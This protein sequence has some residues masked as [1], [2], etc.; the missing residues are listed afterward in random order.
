MWFPPRALTQETPFALG[1]EDFQLL[2]ELAHLRKF[3]T[4]H[5]KYMWKVRM[6]GSLC[7]AD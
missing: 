4:C 1:T 2:E 3:R 5:C 6:A 7:L